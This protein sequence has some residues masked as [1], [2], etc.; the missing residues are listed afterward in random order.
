MKLRNCL[1]TREADNILY[2]S[3]PGECNEISEVQQL[4]V[5]EVIGFT[6]KTF[7][8]CYY[9]KWPIQINLGKQMEKR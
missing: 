5:L 1:S 8:L 9:Y 2:G 4:F 7:S 6:S 3:A